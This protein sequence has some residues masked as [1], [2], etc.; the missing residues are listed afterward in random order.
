MT[1]V[2][3]TT[4]NCINVGGNPLPLAD[5]TTNNVLIGN[6]AYLSKMNN[7]GMTVKENVVIGSTSRSWGDSSVVIGYGAYNDGGT[8]QSTVIGCGAK[9]TTNYG[10]AIGYGANAAGSKSVA[11]GYETEATTGGVIAIGK[12]CTAAVLGPN[13]MGLDSNGI[14]FVE[15]PKIKDVSGSNYDI[16]TKKYVDDKIGDYATKEY[17]DNKIAELITKEYWD[18]PTEPNTIKVGPDGTAR[19]QVG[20]SFYIEVGQSSCYIG[21]MQGDGT[22]IWF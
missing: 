15:H 12:T 17:V 1:Q 20:N 19:L 22:T 14:I 2:K 8:G 5:H 9:S 10:T 21:N 16:A 7:R 4:N 11:I 6:S 18:H 13:T 3:Q